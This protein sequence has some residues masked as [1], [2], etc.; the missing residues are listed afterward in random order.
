[1]PIAISDSPA[2]FWA[3]AVFMCLFVGPVQ[4]SSRTYLARITPPEEAGENF[5]LYATTGRAVS[6]LGPVMFASFI[7]LLGYQR[8][9]AL[10]ISSVLLVGLLLFWSLTRAHSAARPPERSTN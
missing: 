6:F 5:G 9:G 2:V 7:A 3:S 8:A 1:I 10:G 4:S